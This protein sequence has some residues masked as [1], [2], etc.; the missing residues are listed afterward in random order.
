MS[1]LIILDRNSYDG[2]DVA[3]N[4]LRLAQKAASSGFQVR[5]FLINDGVDLGREG[6]K[7]PEGFFDLGEMLKETMRMGVEVKACRTCLHR[8][9]V[10]KGKPYMENVKTA[11]MGELVDG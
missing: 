10:H 2:S 11:T 7:P 9:G 4:A 8:C 5:M 1:L 6:V 3:W